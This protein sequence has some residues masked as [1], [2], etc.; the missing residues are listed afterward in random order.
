MEAEIWSSPALLESGKAVFIASMAEDLADVFT[1]DDNFVVG[2]IIW[3]YK[4]VKPVFSSPSFSHDNEAVFF[5]SY[6]VNC[7]V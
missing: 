4:I 1:L 7:C 3:N 5:F 6:D 2:E